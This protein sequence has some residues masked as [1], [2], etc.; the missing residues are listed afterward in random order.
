M[1]TDEQVDWTITGKNLLDTR[2]KLPEIET[3]PEVKK[4]V[5]KSTVSKVNLKQAL[6]LSEILGTPVGLRRQ[7]EKKSWN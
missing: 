5:V 6:I 7:D 2:P 1:K 3:E 4:A